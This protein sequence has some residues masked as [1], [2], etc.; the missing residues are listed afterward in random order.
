MTRKSV[1]SS[2]I[3]TLILVFAFYLILTRNMAVGL[4]LVNSDTLYLEMIYRGL[5]LNHEPVSHFLLMASPEFLHMLLY[6]ICRLFVSGPP[7]AI[8]AATLISLVLFYLLFLKI[9]RLVTSNKI[10]FQLY[11]GVILLGITL[12][13]VS[14]FWTMGSLDESLAFDDHFLNIGVMN[15]LAL[16]LLLRILFVPGKIA[17]GLIL[18]FVS[19]FFPCLSDPTYL[20]CFVCPALMSLLFCLISYPTLRKKTVA[21]GL[22]VLI[23]ACLGY[24]LLRHL[25]LLHIQVNYNHIENPFHRNILAMIGVLIHA[26]LKWMEV[27]P[28]LFFLWGV[29]IIYLFKINRNNRIFSFIQVFLL[30]MFCVGLLAIIFFDPDVAPGVPVSLH[31][32]RHISPV[33]YLP[34]FFMSV[35][36]IRLF[37]AL[38]T[39]EKIAK[40]FK[41]LILIIQIGILCLLPAVV[42]LTYLFGNPQTDWP[43]VQCIEQAQKQYHLQQGIANYWLARPLILYAHLSI[44]QVT[45]DLY[46]YAWLTDTQT[47]Q[48]ET[49]DFFVTNS[50][51]KEGISMLKKYGAPAKI[52]YCAIYPGSK[53]LQIWLYPKGIS[54]SRIESAQSS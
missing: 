31:I 24:F 53:Q 47:L 52:V 25:D 18:L 23:A 17:L 35:R 1:V 28:P 42:S 3:S 51:S 40:Y 36:M 11:Q 38:G 10:E 48:P 16:W 41:L 33:I 46:P 49:A 27:E 2:A 37:C 5:V 7:H 32:A 22:T 19:V 21:S 12:L 14:F 45:P 15:L 50:G 9:I 6:F 39:Q 43:P 20:T 34:I 13:S 26:F 8:I 29:S 44:E 4:H 30:S 54:V